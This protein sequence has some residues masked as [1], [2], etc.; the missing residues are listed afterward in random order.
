MAFIEKERECEFL[1]EKEKKTSNM[2]VRKRE[3]EG[4]LKK[5]NVCMRVWGEREC[6]SVRKSE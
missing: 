2:C 3:R 5:Q 6:A 4:L 1:S